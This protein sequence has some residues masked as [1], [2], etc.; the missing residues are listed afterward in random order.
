MQERRAGC[1]AAIAP[2]GRLFVVGGGPDGR[3]QHA[4]M[5]ALDPR[6]KRWSQGFASLR[7]GRHYNAASF[8]PDGCLCE[9]LPLPPFPLSFQITHEVFAVGQTW[10]ERFVTRASWTRASAGTRGWTGGRSCPRCRRGTAHR[11]SS[12]QARG[13]GER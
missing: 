2:D 13:C 3:S 1:N 6:E 8:G 7:L 10:P 5:E 9:L 12:A 4:T 11:C